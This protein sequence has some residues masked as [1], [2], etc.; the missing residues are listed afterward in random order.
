MGEL[1]FDPADDLDSELDDDFDE[2][3]DED[4]L[5]E[6][7]SAKTG[8]L[9]KRRLIIISTIIGSVFLIGAVLFG[10]R[11]F[12][13]KKDKQNPALKTSTASQQTKQKAIKKA[14][15]KKKKKIK[16]EK[17]Y[18]LAASE[19]TPILRELSFAGINFSTLQKGKNYSIMVDKDQLEE[20]R[21][22]LAIKGLPAG[23]P[24]GY[25]LLD[26]SQTLGVT[27]FDKRIRFLRALS[28]ELEKAII[29]FNAIEDCKVQIVLPE[30]RLFAVTQPPVTS[31]ILI[32]KAPGVKITDEIVL[33]IIKLI[34]NAVENLQPENVSVIDTD[35]NVLSDG[36]FE[37]MAAKAAG[38]WKTEDAQAKKDAIKELEKAQEPLVKKPQPIIPDFDEIKKWYE[39]KAKFEHSLEKKAIRQLIGVLPA[40]SFKL[41]V[42]S[43]IGPLADGDVLDIKRLAVSVVVDNANED[44]YLDQTLK[45][46]IYTTI[47]GAIGYIKGRD[48]IMLSKADFTLLSD[49]D[50]VKLKKIKATATRNKIIKNTLYVLLP[51]GIFWGL[52][53]LLKKTRKISSDTTKSDIMKSGDDQDTGFSDIQEE[54]DEAKKLDQIKETATTEP[55]ILAKIMEEWLESE[56]EEVSI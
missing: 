53:R 12:S 13:S 9:S 23:S 4:E 1:E 33:G 35:G 32:R 21:N 17:L 38:T 49:E 51:I 52:L 10:A 39:V 55:E 40:G 28:G 15:S 41:S 37:R 48:S 44:I 34:A 50:K 42:T 22:L 18:D 45:R 46:Q 27:E 8:F 5:S 6:S 43:D 36:I 24:K 54:M 56:K 2:A 19:V 47:A 11:A 26:Q 25:D 31:S 16:Y 30:Q 20:A 3:L 14:K 7:G 29:R